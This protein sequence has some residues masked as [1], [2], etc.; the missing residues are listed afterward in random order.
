MLN[1]KKNAYKD[2]SKKIAEYLAAKHKR[3][4]RR[5][6]TLHT[7]EQA[8]GAVG[9]KGVPLSMSDVFVLLFSIAIIL[10]LKSKQEATSNTEA[11]KYLK[12]PRVKIQYS[13]QVQANTNIVISVPQINSYMINN[14]RFNSLEALANEIDQLKKTAGVKTVAI[15]LNAQIPNALDIYLE[16]HQLCKGRDLEVLGIPTE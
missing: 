7:D 6:K 3:N 4:Y 9:D 14:K 13:D 15:D 11:M 1:C 12:I 10:V 5:E 2:D 8:E 16:L